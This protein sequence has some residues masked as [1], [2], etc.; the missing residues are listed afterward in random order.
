MIILKRQINHDSVI[1]TI[2]LMKP[3][4]SMEMKCLNSQITQD[5]KK[6]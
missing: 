1:Q 5:E 6:T 2:Q 3:I 4:L